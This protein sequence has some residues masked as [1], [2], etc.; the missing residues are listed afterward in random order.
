[1]GFL[2]TLQLNVT[3]SHSLPAILRNTLL[4]SLNLEATLVPLLAP[5]HFAL[6]SRLFLLATFTKNLQLK[7]KLSQN[8]PTNVYTDATFW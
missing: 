4:S 1:M 7:D 5:G 6:S 8:I 2:I 3:S